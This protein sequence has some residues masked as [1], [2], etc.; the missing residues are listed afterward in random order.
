MWWHM[1][2]ILTFR[3]WGQKKKAEVQSFSMFGIRLGYMRI[4]L[5]KIELYVPF[6]LK[7]K[8]QNYFWVGESTVHKIMLSCYNAYLLSTTYIHISPYF[9]IS[10]TLNIETIHCDYIHTHYPIFP[11]YPLTSFFP[12]IYPSILIC[13]C[14]RAS[15]FK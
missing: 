11:P 2:V 5:Q 12:T 15:M 6:L 7:D 8:L 14:V 3:A 4:Y 10:T 13:L 1:S 9:E